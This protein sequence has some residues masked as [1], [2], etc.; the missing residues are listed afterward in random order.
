MIMLRR[1]AIFALGSIVLVAC[2][3]EQPGA[4]EAQAREQ[5]ITV[6]RAGA[7]QAGILSVDEGAAPR[8]L[9][10]LVPGG[11]AVIR[12]EQT[13]PGTVRSRL[14]GNFLV[15][16][17]RMLLAPDIAALTVDC[18]SDFE[19]GCPDAY[20]A[21]A[22]RVADIEALVAEA[23]RPLPSI[24]E[25]WLIATS[26]GVI[27]SAAAARHGRG[28]AGIIHAAGVI[29]LAQELGLDFG[30]TTPQFLLHHAADPCGVTLHVSAQRL[31]RARGLPLITAEGGNGFTGRPCEANTQHGFWSIE[32]RVIARIQAIM[33]GTDRSGG[34]LR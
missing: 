32:P 20:Q 15:R 10:V 5:V 28:F 11:S 13:G 16:S 9:A 14:A 12:P 18:R 33:R 1:L 27:A 21:G 22:E 4:A 31:A 25:I 3:S 34:M 17:R 26:R 30:G 23:R 8:F 29:D 2:A 6:P 24:G 7:G 19:G